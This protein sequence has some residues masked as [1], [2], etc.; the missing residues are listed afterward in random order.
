MPTKLKHKKKKTHKTVYMKMIKVLKQEVNKFLKE[1][2][3]TLT[4]TW[5]VKKNKFVQDLKQS[6]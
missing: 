4:N 5:G 3:K 1:I 2:R 6:Q